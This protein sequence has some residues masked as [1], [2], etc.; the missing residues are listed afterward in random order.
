MAV[1][2]PASRRPMTPV[3]RPAPARVFIRTEKCKG[4]RFCMEFCPSGALQLSTKFNAKGYHY[5]VVVKDV[6]I[7]CS[8]CTLICPDYAIF[9]L[10]TSSSNGATRIDTDSV[11]D[12]PAVQRPNPSKAP[13]E[14]PPERA[15]CTA[16]A[17]K[18][19]PDGNGESRSD[20]ADAPECQDESSKTTMTA[21]MASGEMPVGQRE[22]RN[23]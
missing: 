2:T 13:T 1:K 7:N 17:L 22:A 11:P 15:E 19:T 14:L 10:P 12:K 5:P 18:D 21:A 3:P 8:L 4:C 9:S 23:Q 20:P 6:C 16:C